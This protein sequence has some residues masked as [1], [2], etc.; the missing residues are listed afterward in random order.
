MVCVKKA[1]AGTESC[2]WPPVEIN[3]KFVQKNCLKCL[4]TFLKLSRVSIRTE[5]T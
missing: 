3:L 1:V 5:G 2:I 4:S